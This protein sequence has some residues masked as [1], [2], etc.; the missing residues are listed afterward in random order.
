MKFKIARDYYEKD[1]KIYDR[2]NIEIQPGVTV[3]IGCKGSG[4]TTLLKQIKNTCKSKDIP[5]ISFDNL[6]QGGSNALSYAG[7]MGD[8]GFVTESICSSEGEN[9]NMN[10]ARFATKIGR[11]IRNNLTAKEVV[12]LL[13]A[14]DSG[15]SIDYLIEVKELL[16]KTI[17]QDCKSKGIEVYI[18][19]SANEYEMARGE[20]CFNVSTC[21][22]ENILTYESYRKLIIKTRQKKN[23]R[24]GFEEYEFE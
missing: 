1:K 3:L 5:V 10:I 12:I 21:K 22:Y 13:D 15:L 11:F 8:F 24:Y 18:I 14:I 2:A 20:S 7:I 23:K 17:L 19:V 9:I 16:F 6:K 4:K